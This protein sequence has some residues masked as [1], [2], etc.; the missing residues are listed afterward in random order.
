MLPSNVATYTRDFVLTITFNSTGGTLEGV[1][2]ELDDSR[3]NNP[4]Q[5]RIEDYLA[6]ERDFNLSEATF[7]TNGVITGKAVLQEC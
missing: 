1:I 3:I 7:D 4:N 6:Y 2:Q 5:A